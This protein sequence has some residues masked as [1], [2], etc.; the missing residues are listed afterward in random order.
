MYIV[1]VLIYSKTSPYYKD[2]LPIKILN[3]NFLQECIYFELKS[4]LWTIVSLYRS[5]SQSAYGIDY[6]KEFFLTVV[7]CDFNARS[8]KWWTD[9]KTIQEGFKRETLLSQFSLS[10]VINEA[11]QISQNFNSCIDLLFTNQ[12]NFIISAFYFP[13]FFLHSLAYLDT[14]TIPFSISVSF[15]FDNFSTELKYR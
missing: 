6:S 3:I 11:T 13:V 15:F 1:K 7:I 14:W 2:S 8:S 9:N 10:Q 12:Q 5:P 4:K